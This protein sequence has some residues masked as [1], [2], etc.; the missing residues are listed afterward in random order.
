MC[1]RNFWAFWV[2]GTV[3]KK[4]GELVRSNQELARFFLGGGAFLRAAHITYLH[5]SEIEMVA[6][7]ALSFST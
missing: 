3:P 6:G 1:T 2:S 5:I 7:A 4:Q